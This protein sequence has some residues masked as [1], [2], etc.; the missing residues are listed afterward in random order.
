[1]TILDRPPAPTGQPAGSANPPRATPQTFPAGA[2]PSG[3]AAPPIDLIPT[4][5]GALA[6]LAATL[7][8]PP[9][10]VGSS[11]VGATIEVVL[12]I[13]AVGVGARLARVPV[14]AAI[15]LQLLGAAIALTALYTVGGIGGV[16]PNGAVINEAGELLTGAWEQIR[17]NVS[18]APSSTELSFLICLSVGA[19]ALIVDILIAVCRAPALVALPLLCVY[20]VPA[21]MDL[22]MLPWEAF[23]APAMLYAVL[24]VASGLVGRRHGAGAGLAQVINGVGLAALA[25]VIA[26][27][28]AGSVTGIGTEGRLPRTA[29]GSTTGIGLSPFA[30]L[31]ASLEQSDPVEMLRVSGLDSPHY[32]RT[33]SLEVLSSDYDWN[34]D[35]LSEDQLP[36]GGDL[37]GQQL[38]TITPAAYRSEYLPIYDGTD[39]ITGIDSEW[40]YDPALD[41]VHRPE[42]TTPGPYQVSTAFAQPSVEDLRADTVTSG[43]ELTETGDLPAEVVTIANDVTAG[44]SNAF[45]KADALRSYFTNPANGFTY[46]LDVPQGPTDDPL[47]NF[48]T[49]K[50]GACQQYASSMAVMLRALAIPARVAIGFTQ[51]TR[52][53]DGTYVISSNDAH[54]WVEVD[55]DGAGWVQFD[56]TPLGG[57]QGGQQGFTDN[58]AAAPTTEVT[59]S[60]PAPAPGQQPD[61]EGDNSGPTAA[62]SSAGAVAGDTDNGPIVPFW[63]W[64]SLAGI[65]LVAAAAA[66]PTVV[67]RRRRQ[68]RLQLAEAGGPDGAAAAWREIEDLAVDHGI[69]LN[70]AESARVAAN[71]LAKAAHLHNQGRAELRAVVEAA[72]ENWYGPDSAGAPN[73][74]RG[75]SADQ[76]R[77]GERLSAGVGTLQRPTQAS[78]LAAAP[79]TMAAELQH[80]VPLSLLDRLV[81]R[82]VRPAWWRF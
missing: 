59:A 55:F 37:S 6:V 2:A 22:M 57:G 5:L 58:G 78:N 34:F 42:A 54:A 18:P 4:L 48:L 60:A 30:S 20:S 76:G 32:L 65:L 44:A 10:I 49:N 43:G 39:A 50:Q 63:M 12:V 16:I 7:A 17:T 53:A 74:D 3:P 41:T 25:T 40:T 46:S 13:W 31:S 27:V 66:G 81:P 64:W 72:E 73:A 51:G 33:I 47:V 36:S 61:I 29:A 45:D 35:G 56:P 14:V 80:N 26:L 11:W 52:E 69:G 71:R 15:I 28:V 9:M 82:S 24:L 8:I 23:A 19:T 38:I 75:N 67:R 70:P 62:P 68:Q 21:S 79:R 77:S 1:M